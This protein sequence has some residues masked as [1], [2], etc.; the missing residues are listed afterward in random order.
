MP[1]PDAPDPTPTEPDAFS[2]SDDREEEEEEN[3]DDDIPCAVH[4]NNETCS[5]S[6]ET[7]AAGEPKNLDAE[8]AK[9]SDGPLESKGS[10]SAGG[11]LPQ[12]GQVKVEVVESDNEDPQNNKGTFKDPSFICCV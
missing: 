11:S 5:D 4:Q 1:E 2:E 9:H 3:G 6:D 7:P 10:T 8:F 12:D